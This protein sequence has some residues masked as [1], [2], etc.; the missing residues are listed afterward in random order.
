MAELE[1]WW[2]EQHPAEAKEKTLPF[3]FKKLFALRSTA[4]MSLMRKQ[5]LLGYVYRARFGEFGAGVR[6]HSR[7][8]TRRTNKKKS[9]F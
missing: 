1:R 4:L 2:R 6:V 8:P 9:V 7:R 5:R 3:N